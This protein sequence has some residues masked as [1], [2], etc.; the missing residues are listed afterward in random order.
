[1]QKPDT[2]NYCIDSS[3]WLAYFRGESTTIK[4]VIEEEKTVTSALALI[5]VADRCLHYGKT[6]TETEEVLRF[7][8][9]H[10]EIVPVDNDISLAAATIKQAVRNNKPKFGI[11][12]ATHLATARLTSTTLLTKD[13]DFKDLTPVQLIK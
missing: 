10:A 7:M 13:L 11:V 5:E 6:Q 1:M 3:A 4:S 8:S 12:D 9:A 2:N